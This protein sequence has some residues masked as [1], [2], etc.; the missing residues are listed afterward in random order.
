MN[1][2][3]NKEIEERI[4]AIYKE[5]L[6]ELPENNKI[7]GITYYTDITLVT[8]VDGKDGLADQGV[9]AVRIVNEKE[10]NLYKLYNNSIEIAEID[11]NGKI[12][13]SNEYI[14]WL[15]QIDKRFSEIAKNANE[16]EALDL[17]NELT[18][19]DK[20]YKE[21][22]IKELES[23]ENK[24]I[25]EQQKEREKEEPENKEQEMQQ[26]AEATGNKVENI[27][28][29]SKIKPT[30]YL[31]DK[32][33][34]EEIANVKGQYS[35]IYI[36]NANEDMGKNHKF[37]FIGRNQ[38]GELEYIEGLETKG[39]TTTDRQIYSIN[40]DGSKVEEKQVT[41]MFTTSDP[42]K[43]FSAKIGNYGIIEVDYLRKSPTENKFV[44]SQVET[45]TERPTTAEVKQFMNE[46]RTTKSELDESIDKT[47]KQIEENE[48]RTTRLENIDDN[49]NNDRAIDVTEVVE[50]DDGTKTT[51]MDE[52]KSQNKKLDDY[53]KE[54]EE[55]PESGMAEK[56]ES[57]RAKEL[58]KN[59]KEEPEALH[60]RED[61]GERE[62]PEEAAL[63]RLMN[64]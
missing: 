3:E 17:N 43:M 60:D 36:V 57:I 24:E 50:L 42:N 21:D 19:E 14:E 34:F 49:P 45:Q 26:I 12:I 7:D 59:T 27:K 23:E 9:Y 61:R 5:V 4:L 56:I 58:E 38:D 2:D 47:E 62:T 28:S 44:G 13:F 46:A 1:P 53:I 48:S 32:D 54:I 6:P 63:R 55:T 30:Q 8:P 16:K 11:E 41:E 29:Y 20:E 51:I 52:A 22:E 25:T 40:R 35:D 39:T 64:N 33:T 18:E 15:E 31:T 37:A 10:K